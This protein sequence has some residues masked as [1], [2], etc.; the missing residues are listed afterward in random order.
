MLYISCHKL[1]PLA[2]ILVLKNGIFIVVNDDDDNNNDDDDNNKFNLSVYSF[3][4]R[5]L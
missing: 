4:S 1:Q 5:H 2:I 3:F